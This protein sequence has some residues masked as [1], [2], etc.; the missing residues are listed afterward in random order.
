MCAREQGEY[1]LIDP[2]LLRLLVDN[3]TN[4]LLSELSLLIENTR[5]HLRFCHL[6][7]F[8]E[9][10]VLIQGKVHILA[11]QKED[12]FIFRKDRANHLPSS[13]SSQ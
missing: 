6:K 9:E 3:N 12:W 8:R 10:S 5:A 13:P 2:Q 1:I 7:A 4:P 11:L